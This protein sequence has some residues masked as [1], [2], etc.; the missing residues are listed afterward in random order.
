[1]IGGILA[2]AFLI[3]MIAGWAVVPVLAAGGLVSCLASRKHWLVVA[4]AIC[5]TVLGVQRAVQPVDQAWD[6]AVSPV[7]LS[8]GQIVSAVIDDGRTQRFKVRL[9]NGSQ[10]C[11]RAFTRTELGRG[12]QL[13]VDV[14]PDR[15]GALPDGFRAYLRAQQCDLSGTVSRITIL[16]SG[17]GVMRS[18]DHVRTEIVLRFV[19]WVP[20]DS[21]ALLAGLVV[22]DDSLLSDETM[23]DFETT[24]TLHVVAISGS[25]LTLLIS[26]LLIASAWSTRRRMTDMLGMAAIWM[27][28]LV[29]GAG[30]PTLRAG[31]L[32][33]AAAGARALG[34]PG[35]LL[36]LSLQVAAIQAALWPSSVL[37]LSYRLS[38]VAIFGVLIA[39]AGRNFSGLLGS[40]KLVIMTTL[41]VNA[42]LIPILPVESRP[43]FLVSILT[44]TLIAPLISIAFVLG[45]LALAASILHPIAGEPIALLAGV[46]NDV[47]ILVVRTTASW[48]WIPPPFNWDGSGLPAPVLY[49]LATGILLGVSTEFRRAVGDLRRQLASVDETS[50]MLVLGSGLGACVALLTLGVIR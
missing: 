27:Y 16:K 5:A 37:G 14:V 25:N 31:F 11:A 8:R 2:A 40:L 23:D 36:T 3:G 41:V 45:L 10:L 34:R 18:F 32:A 46:I 19:A 20:G 28:V 24:G 6:M 15:S 26:M 49:V 12:D 1:M 30:P 33:T 9:E 7:D 43:S 48:D 35:D 13:A 22:G 47:S 38:T 50:G 29:G 39:T 17:G 4:L 42:L 44:N 21:G